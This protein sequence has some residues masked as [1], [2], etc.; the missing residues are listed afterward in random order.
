MSSFKIKLLRS[1]EPCFFWANLFVLAYLLRKGVLT[2]AAASR[3][4]V[5]L[6]PDLQDSHV[7]RG[8]WPQVWLSEVRVSIKKFH[9]GKGHGGGGEPPFG[10]SQTIRGF[11]I[12]TDFY[13][14]FSV[15]HYCDEK[16]LCVLYLILTLTL[17]HRDYYPLCVC[18][19][20]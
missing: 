9:Q 6:L 16:A 8:R 15:G 2:D 14:R 1:W 17:R 11:S 13:L 18:L 4:G 19:K 12:S 20:R 10:Y 3:A 5:L 7:G